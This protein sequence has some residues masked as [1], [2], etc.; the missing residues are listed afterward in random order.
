MIVGDYTGDGV[1]DFAVHRTGAE[2]H[3]FYQS[4]ANVLS[5]AW[6]SGQADDV[7]VPGDFNGDG[8]YDFVFQRGNV[9]HIRI[10]GT[11][12][13]STV[14]FGQE[15]D[16]TVPADYDG[17]GIT[18]IAVISDVGGSLQWSIRPSSAPLTTIVQVWGVSSSAHPDLAV[19]GDYDGDG[20]ADFA[21][22]R[23]STGEFLVKSSGTGTTWTVVLGE[24]DDFPVAAFSVG[25][26]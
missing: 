22:W 11:S 21:V 5:V 4:G 16:I 15:F 26:Q 2:N 20:K 10:N 3:Y 23:Q 12:E 24:L 25:N 9:F 13:T 6:G 19:P 14:T 8:K 17:D 7:V 18:D 1:D